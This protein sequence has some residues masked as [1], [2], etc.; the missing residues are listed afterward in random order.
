MKNNVFWTTNY[1]KKNNIV[2][3]KLVITNLIMHLTLKPIM[4]WLY[5]NILYLKYRS[6]TELGKKKVGEEELQEDYEPTYRWQ[7]KYVAKAH[8]NISPL[9]KVCDISRPTQS[10]CYLHSWLIHRGYSSLPSAF[11]YYSY[12]KLPADSLKMKKSLFSCAYKTQLMLRKVGINL[13]NSRIT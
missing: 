12:A 1:L 7:I 3:Q 11:F 8:S 4:Y 2:K 5:S 6:H 9:S 10:D 13:R